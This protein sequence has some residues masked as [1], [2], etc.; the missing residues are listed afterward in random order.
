MTT[1]QQKEGRN[2][3]FDFLKPSHSLFS[4]FT[5]YVDQYS[6]LLNPSQELKGYLADISKDK[7]YI[8]D[9]ITRR[10]E[11][12]VHQADMKK[13]EEEEREAERVAYASVDWHDFV[14]VDTIEFVEADEFAE[15]PPPMD[16]EVL[17]KINLSSDVPVAN[18]SG[19]LDHEH[20]AKKI[21]V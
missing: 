19:Q 18:P 15:F 12:Q 16:L 3:Q 20:V 10:S 6:K 8:M 9:N 11:Y 1:L 13:K 7:F 17:K 5:K 4:L 2:Y 21:K 14:I